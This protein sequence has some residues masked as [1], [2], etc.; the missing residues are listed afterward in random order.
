MIGG[1][2]A[3]SGENLFSSSGDEGVRELSLRAVVSLRSDIPA[4][5]E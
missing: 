1:C 5:V 2:G 4:V 3:A